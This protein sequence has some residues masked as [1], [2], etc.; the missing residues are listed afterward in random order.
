MRGLLLAILFLSPLRASSGESEIRSMLRAA[1]R[2]ADEAG[3]KEPDAKLLLSISEEQYRAGDAENAR[4][5]LLVATRTL[6]SHGGPCPESNWLVEIARVQWESGGIAEASATMRTV[7]DA[8]IRAERKVKEECLERLGELQADI[9]DMEGALATAS[10]IPGARKSDLY[11]RIAQAFGRQARWKEA[12]EAA[13]LA[14]P[15]KGDPAYYE[16]MAR[17]ANAGSWREAGAIMEKIDGR[18]SDGFYEYAAIAAAQ[19]GDLDEAMKIARSVKRPGFFLW[20]KISTAM[21]SHGRAAEAIRL[22]SSKL[23][24]DP[25]GRGMALIHIADAQEQSGDRAGAERTRLQALEASAKGQPEGHLNRRIHILADQGRFD[26]IASIR[27][28]RL[29]W[30]IKDLCQEGGLDAAI[31]LAGMVGMDGMES[32]AAAAVIRAQIRKGDAA[33]ALKSLEAAKNSNVYDREGL[34]REIAVLQ[35]GQGDIPGALATV[36]LLD[37]TFAWTR[38]AA[39]EAV[40]QAQT[41]AAELPEPPLWIPSLRDADE[42][43]R[44]WLGAARGMRLR[45]EASNRRR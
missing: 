19:A 44:A 22:V 12:A 42:K 23:S 30:L 7:R 24:K 32:V 17:R 25:D 37:A 13:G 20:W 11:P 14:T 35:A 40:A 33:A 3:R 27:K 39:L 9:G 18:G 26:E 43:A 21:A 1:R 34:V 5:T 10:L 45:E 29:S 28:D 4:A 38:P 8:G 36:A 15:M 31:T 16:A 6:S 41:A 2:Y